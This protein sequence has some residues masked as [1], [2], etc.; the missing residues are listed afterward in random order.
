MLCIVLVIL[1]YL[2]LRK[3]N[4]MY[5]SS[6]FKVLGLEKSK[7]SSCSSDFKVLADWEKQM[8]VCFAWLCTIFAIFYLPYEKSP[9]V[10]ASTMV[11]ST[12]TFFLFKIKDRLFVFLVA[13]VLTWVFCLIMSVRLFLISSDVPCFTIKLHFCFFSAFLLVYYSSLVH[14]YVLQY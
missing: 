3:A 1:R 9:R 11:L 6:D 8:C 14:V 7:C 10:L 2:G 5:C 4:V 12:Y 13:Q